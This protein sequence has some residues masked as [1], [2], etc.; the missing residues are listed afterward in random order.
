MK[1]RDLAT[2]PRRDMLMIDPRIIQVEQGFNLR[3]LTT[4]SAQ[5]GLMELAQDIANNGF[6][7]GQ[8]LTV[9]LKDDKPFV[10]H[11]HRRR[12]ATIIAIEQLG[13][14]IKAIPCIG[15]E[16]GTSDA[17]RT[18][19]VFNTNNGVHLEPLEKVVGIKRLL[20]FGW[21]MEEIAKKCGLGSVQNV[22]SYLVLGGAPMAVQAM[23]RNDEVSATTAVAVTR[24]HGDQAEG[25][26][27]EAK[28]RA[29]SEGKT[30]IT[31]AHVRATTGEFQPTAG[32]VKVLIAA[33]QKI[34]IG[35]VDD[36]PPAIATAA[37]ETVGLMMKK[38][39]EAA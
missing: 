1:L 22:E 17:D 35:H 23:V 33:L 26:L 14:D 6:N 29:K 15:E 38:E 25:V 16:K 24:K 34:A 39:R 2:G 5:A 7:I 27:T 8:P 18:A 9:R 21:S 3:D 36:D 37:L 31:N 20:G 19:D 28:Q 13:A 4:P 32:N 11:G 10:V 12:L 30:R